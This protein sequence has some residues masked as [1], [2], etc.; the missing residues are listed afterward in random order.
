V[1][2]Q[3]DNDLVA[4][5]TRVIFEN[6]AALVAAHP[7]ARHLVRPSSF[8]GVPAPY[9]AGAVRYYQTSNR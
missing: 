8:D 6:T 3:L 1:S 9:H 2:S 4:E 7:E 5:I